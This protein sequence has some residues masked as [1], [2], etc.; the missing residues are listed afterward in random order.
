MKHLAFLTLFLLPLFAVS[1]FPG[2]I[3]FTQ[4]DGSTFQGNLKGDEWFNYVS[5]PNEYLAVY[6]KTTK[7]YEYAL[8]KEDRLTPSG[9]VVD[10]QLHKENPGEL[11][12]RIPK[13]DLAS[14]AKLRSDAQQKRPHFT[15][16]D[17]H[18]KSH[19]KHK[20]LKT[21]STQWKEILKEK[22]P[23]K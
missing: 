18:N 23:L 10:E 11:R 6:N 17:D 4:H 2:I 3:T 7:N 22:D 13:I 5:L 12:K 14:I 9:I 16:Q 8:V 21:K 20:V 1:A 15:Q 19:Y